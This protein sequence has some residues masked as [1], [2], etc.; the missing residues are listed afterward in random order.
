MKKHNMV[1]NLFMIAL[2]IGGIFAAGAENSGFA[3]DR[4][5]VLTGGGRTTTTD[6][7]GQVGS[8]GGTGAGGSGCCAS[9]ANSDGGG[10]LGSGAKSD[11]TGFLGGGTRTQ[12][13]QGKEETNSLF[14][15]ILRF[16]F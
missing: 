4:G 12:E 9:T 10:A 15:S 6:G 5:G 14:Y 11:G 3:Q 8:G 16:F 7:T 13:Q 1:R 2:L